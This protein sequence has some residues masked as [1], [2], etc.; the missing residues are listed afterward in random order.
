MCRAMSL[1]L[2]EKILFGL[3][4]EFYFNIKAPFS[5]GATKNAIL[6]SASLGLRQRL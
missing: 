1:Q 2:L 5:I 6:S 4:I 3:M